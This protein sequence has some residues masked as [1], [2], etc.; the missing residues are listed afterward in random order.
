[1]IA[2]TRRKIISYMIYYTSK[3]KTFMIRNPQLPAVVIYNSKTI[4]LC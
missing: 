2:H 3:K 1:M 4:K